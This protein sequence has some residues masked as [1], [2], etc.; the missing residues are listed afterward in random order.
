MLDD[1]STREVHSGEYSIG[2]AVGFQPGTIGP[3]LDEGAV[4][5]PQRFGYMS[6]TDPS[7]PR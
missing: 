2:I 6:A 5:T 3:L 1:E 4:G 7:I